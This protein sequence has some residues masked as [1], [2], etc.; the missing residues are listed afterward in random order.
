MNQNNFDLIR[1]FA[2]LQV[3]I[4][5]G[6]GYLKI[7]NTFIAFFIKILEFFPGVPIFFVISGFL[8]SSS[9]ERSSSL[10]AYFK[11][12]FL[13]IYPALWVSILLSLVA[14]YIF[15]PMEK[16]GFKE[17]SAWIFARGTIFQFYHNHYFDGFGMGNPNGALWT[18]SL[19]LQFYILLPL[20]YFVMLQIHNK[21]IFLS[22]LFFV[23]CG[24]NVYFAFNQDSAELLFKLLRVSVL[25]YLYM[26]IVGIIIQRNIDSLRKMVF[27]KAAVWFFAYVAVAFF[28]KEF[29]YIGS[30]TLINP[31]QAVIL[32]FMVAAFAYTKVSLS[33]RLLSNNDISYGIYLYHLIVVN[34]FLEIGLIGNIFYLFCMLAVSAIIAFLSWR[35]VEKP[36]LTLKKYTL[37]A[38]A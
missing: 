16:I 37:H 34:V 28:M 15:Y 17:L 27:N 26:F 38:R 33:D 9:I 8:I 30:G 24:L 5:H 7:D 20:I 29:G 22:A 6:Y 11:N 32:G 2:A 23:F 14:L 3:A 21:N 35:V 19:E 4:T 25:P 12:R 18:I 1:L 31:L 36:A 10:P 13:R